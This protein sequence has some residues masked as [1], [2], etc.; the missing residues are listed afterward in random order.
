MLELQETL[1]LAYLFISHD[2]A[3]I[4]RM[5]H[6]VAVMHRGVIVEAGSRRAVFESPQDAYTRALMSAVPLPIPQQSRST[7]AA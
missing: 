4:E 1:G 2:M 7:L 3:V 6:N 5:S